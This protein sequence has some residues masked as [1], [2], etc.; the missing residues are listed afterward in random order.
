MTTNRG[1]FPGINWSESGLTRAPRSLVFR[2][3]QPSVYQ[4]YAVEKLV[5]IP[6]NAEADIALIQKGL[7]EQCP[8][9]TV[10]IAAPDGCREMPGFVG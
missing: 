7:S 6:A 10:Q 3:N 9:A 8:T 4:A 5:L 1:F 2:F